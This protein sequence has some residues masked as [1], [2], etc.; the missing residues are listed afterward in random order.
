MPSVSSRRNHRSRSPML[1]AMLSG[2]SGAS[3]SRKGTSQSRVSKALVQLRGLEVFV[4]RLPKEECRLARE[5]LEGDNLL[6]REVAVVIVHLHQN[7]IS[8]GC[9]RLQGSHELA[10]FPGRDSRI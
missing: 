5:I 3:R 8:R 6:L 7:G 10:R 9:C 1:S 2:S 4:T